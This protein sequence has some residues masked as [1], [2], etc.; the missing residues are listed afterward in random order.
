MLGENRTKLNT[1][2][3]FESFPSGKYTLQISDVNQISTTF[4]GKEQDKFKFEFLILTDKKF[5]TSEDKEETTRGR[6]VWNS[7]STYISPKSF[8]ASF[9]KIL[10]PSISTMS[11]EDKEN[12][13]LD[14]LIGKQIDALIS[15]DLSKDGEKYWNNIKSFEKCEEEL[16]GFED[17][18]GKP[19]IKNKESV[20]VEAPMEDIIE[21]TTEEQEVETAEDFVKNMEKQN[22]SAK[23]EDDEIK[24]MENELA[25]KKAEKAKQQV[26]VN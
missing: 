24:R 2:G 1:G 11:K 3:G 8:L 15:K 13:N 12:Y 26:A 17:L 7:F 18:P 22:E 10:D 4:N 23:I 6:K 21:D 16:E 19:L 9:V 20:P 25:M 14:S 5:K